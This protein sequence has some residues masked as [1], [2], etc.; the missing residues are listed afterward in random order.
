MARM[1]PAEI[2]KVT[3]MNPGR[4]PRGLHLGIYG[5]EQNAATGLGSNMPTSHVP[6]GK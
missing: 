6:S 2:P 5:G 4:I 3:I 1:I